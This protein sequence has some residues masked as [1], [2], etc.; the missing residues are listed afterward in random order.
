MRLTHFLFI[1]FAIQKGEKYIAG[2]GAQIRRQQPKEGTH[3]WG[4][5]V[6]VPSLCEA[7]LIEAR[8]IRACLGMSQLPILSWRCHQREG[9]W[10]EALFLLPFRFR[11]WN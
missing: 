8:Y 9:T 7:Q 2:I 1:I 11:G 5:T 3:L 10:V 6:F 4:I